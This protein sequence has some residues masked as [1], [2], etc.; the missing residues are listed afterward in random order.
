MILMMPAF[1]EQ[2][3]CIGG[4]CTD[5]C[6][7]G[8]EID[9]D[10]DALARYR[11]I[12]GEW[13]QRLRQNIVGEPPHFRLNGER[14]AF[15]NGDNLCDLILWGGEQMLCE[16][17]D[18]HPRFRSQYG[19]RLEVGAGLC[20]EVAA[21]QWLCAEG[22][23]RFVEVKAEGAPKRLT[24]EQ[25]RR[26]QALMPLRARIWEMLAAGRPLGQR[27][28]QVL[29]L[30]ERAQQA[31]DAGKPKR[32]LAML[33]ADGEA[34]RRLVSDERAVESLDA[35]CL[36]ALKHMEPIDARWSAIL[37]RLERRLPELRAQ[38]AALPDRT[39]AY[40]R[41]TTY[42]VYRYLLKGAL[43]GDILSR[44]K[45]AVLMA[46]ITRR[47]DA[48]FLWERGGWDAALEIEAAKLLSKQVEYSQENMTLMLSECWNSR[49]LTTD[50]MIRAMGGWE[51]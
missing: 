41:L 12:P 32:I 24:K 28:A 45:W 34:D 1:H 17:C 35:G 2:F 30:A 47:L 5:N 7:V 48:L 39:N 21:R 16:I 43:D 40:A 26:L 51:E 23:V 11:A 44:A 20:C 37:A 27:F 13:G 49:W 15:L 10:R 18:Q 46:W 6:C 14:C 22:P 50:A 36:S 8:W 9:I 3:R 31:L 25:D 33:D 42:A 19:D 38:R 4:R 29:S